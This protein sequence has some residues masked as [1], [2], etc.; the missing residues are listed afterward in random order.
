MRCVMPYISFSV[1]LFGQILQAGKRTI[2]L[3]GICLIPVLNVSAQ[4]VI[5]SL[6][7]VLDG[8]H[9][10]RRAE[11]L[12]ELSGETRQKNI[13]KAIAQAQQALAIV[14][15]QG[16]E[17]LLSTS[18]ETLGWYY[19]IVGQDTT[20]IS[21]YLKAL[22]LERKHGHRLEEAS[23]L[24]DIGR[25]YMFQGNHPKALNYLF[26]ALRIYEEMGKPGESS[27]VLVY[28]GRI[29]KVRK[30]FKQAISF[31]GEAYE[32]AKKV[33]DYSEITFAAAGAAFA[34]KKMEKYD[35]AIAFFKKALKSANNIR[36]PHRV[37]AKANILLGMSSVYQ[38]Q[39]LFE[40]AI[41]LSHDQLKL[42]RSNESRML[43]AYGYENL[44]GLYM[45]RGNFERSNQYLKRAIELY[46]S[47]GLNSS[48]LLNSLAKNYIKQQKFA[49]ALRVANQGLQQAKE[50]GSVHDVKKLLKTIIHVYMMQKNYQQAFQ[51]QTELIAVNARMY[52]QEKAQQIAEM[53]TRYE[54]KQKEQ[55]I[56]LL[57]EKQENAEL[58]RNGLIIG[59]VL[60][61]IIAFLVYKRQRLKIK[62][63]KTDI[64]NTRLKKKQLEQEVEFKNKQLTTHSLHLVQKNEAM[65]ELKKSINDIQKSSD[66]LADKKL[67]D[68]HHLVD[69]SFNL[70]K[71]WDEFKHYFEE[72]HTGFFNTL[73]KSYPDLT[74][75]ELRLAALV[76]LNLTIKEVA[77]ILSISPN[78]VKTAR[79]RL[80]KK[81]G[82]KT[83]ENLTDFMMKMEKEA[84]DKGK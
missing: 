33:D 59:L 57:Q 71:D 41:Q 4:S 45:A 80:R 5:D 47:M 32:L 73:K 54:T 82:M 26:Q 6:K 46:H 62:K 75:G 61:L 39:Q 24:Y 17:E 76:K 67:N 81:L 18:L 83:E 63:N 55:Q 34:F 2:I 74:S 66:G 56:V 60:I 31:Y 37:H 1:S 23:I 3:L 13:E 28:V 27:E 35:K 44:A 10:I 52:N 21:Y 25:F 29:Y 36:S 43:Q 11:L 72:V 64:E 20:A 12:L 48:K 16:D 53:Q 9:G 58:L 42:A 19:S 65:K 14:K 38:D 79:Y 49:K 77:T 50:S 15:R 40:K 7:V 69:Y 78:S 51:A 22:R 68:L 8:T 84:V 30:K 70:D